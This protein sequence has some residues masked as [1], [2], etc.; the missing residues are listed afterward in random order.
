[1]SLVDRRAFLESSKQILIQIAAGTTVLGGTA[2]FVRGAEPRRKRPEVVVVYYPHW[3][4]Y[5]HGS[6]WKGEGWTEWE[7]MKAAVARFPGHHQPL[8][9]SW[10]QCLERM[11][12]G[13][14]P[15]PGATDRDRLSGSHSARLR[16]AGVGDTTP[17]PRRPGGNRPAACWQR[18]SEC[19]GPAQ[20]RI[21]KVTTADGTS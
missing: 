4:S 9:P 15:A 12:R 13:L 20:I 5:D 3:H 16:L 8:Q 21:A 11:D 18:P 19:R 7:G 2:P 10:G 17:A 14:L 1:M 6:S